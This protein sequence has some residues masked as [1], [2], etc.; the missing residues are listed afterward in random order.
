MSI[1]D[2]G[3]ETKEDFA[4]A[5]EMANPYFDKMVAELGLAN[6]AIMQSIRDGISPHIAM[7][8]SDD[9]LDALFAVGIQTMQ[10]G[11][12]AQAQVVFDKL[13]KLKSYDYRFWYALG[14]TYQA[15]G[16]VD[17]AARCYIVSLGFQATDV[18]GYLRLGECLLSAKETAEALEV[19][20]IAAAL[21]DDGHGTP[22]AHEVALRMITH[23]EDLL[24]SAGPDSDAAALKGTA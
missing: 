5:L 2:L 8:L 11:D 17:M 22:D 10:A 20:Q 15:Q 4:A 6:D 19:Y 23:T 16:T 9:H 24:A 3:Y 14:T 7:D 12:V 21:C 18:D 1:L 13:T